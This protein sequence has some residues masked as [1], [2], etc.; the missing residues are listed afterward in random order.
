MAH[1][2][3]TVC[4]P[5][6]GGEAGAAFVELHMRLTVGSDYPRAAPMHSFERSR[7]LSDKVLQRI[8]LA[9]DAAV[10]EADSGPCLFQLLDAAASAIDDANTT[11][12]DED[13]QICLEPLNADTGGLASAAV[14]THRTE[15]SH[16]FHCGCLAPWWRLT[17]A[18]VAAAM[19]TA[20][21][22]HP[23]AGQVRG[24][25]ANLERAAAE[26]ERASEAIVQV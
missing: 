19:E 10:A 6:T 21:A 5:R 13:C 11:L 2:I 9:L 16:Y 20:R 15:C 23:L 25:E 14:A 22:T 12:E 8:S 17:S 7:G 18:A 1:V 4:K 24:D 26:A 3:T